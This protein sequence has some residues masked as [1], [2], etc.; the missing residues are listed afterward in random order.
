MLPQV[1]E[2]GDLPPSGQVSA[3]FCFPAFMHTNTRGSNYKS[4]KESQHPEGNW[5]SC[6][7]K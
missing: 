6:S 4:P 3:T 2:S 7:L 1:S 5:H